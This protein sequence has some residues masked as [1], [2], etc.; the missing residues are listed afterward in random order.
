M[1]HEEG[2]LEGAEGARIYW[3]AWLPEGESRASVVLSHGISEHSARYAHLGGR[4]VESGFGLYALDHRGHGHSDGTGA[5]IGRL[6]YVVT[7][8]LRLVRLVE[9]RDGGRR[10]FLLG[11]S[12]GGE[13]ALAFALEHQ[14]AIAGLLLSGPVAV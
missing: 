6:E 1:T 5:N 9:E 12:M 2:W 13:F 4:L 7:D 11:H 8:L 10:P 3:Q 14:E